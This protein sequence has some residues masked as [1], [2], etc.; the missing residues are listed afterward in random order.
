VRWARLEWTGYTQGVADCLSAQP[1][2][3]REQPVLSVAE[4]ATYVYGLPEDVA[5]PQLMTRWLAD[6]QADL[7]DL[8]SCLRGPAAEAACGDDAAHEI[9]RIALARLEA[10]FPEECE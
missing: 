4:F 1:L 2:C 9:V 5:V 3:V 10:L 6:G 8:R 7:V